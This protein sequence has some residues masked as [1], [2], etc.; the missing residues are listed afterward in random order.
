MVRLSGIAVCLVALTA[1]ATPEWDDATPLGCRV[2]T[3]SVTIACVPRADGSLADCAVV[4]ESAPGCGFSDTALEAAAKARLRPTDTWR[5]GERI[6]LTTR[7]RSAPQ[8]RRGS[9]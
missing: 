7:F 2:T 3:A 9:R 1:C 4:R 8:F 5:E 6:L